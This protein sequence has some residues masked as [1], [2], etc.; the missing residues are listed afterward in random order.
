MVTGSCQL[1]IHVTLVYLILRFLSKALLTELFEERQHLMLK[2]MCFLVLA[3]AFD[4][5]LLLTCFCFAVSLQLLCFFCLS[6]PNQAYVV[7]TYVS[8]PCVRFCTSQL[9]LRQSLQLANFPKALDEKSF[10]VP[11]EAFL[12]HDT[13]RSLTDLQETAQWLG[14]QAVPQSILEALTGYP[15]QT[16]L[17]H[18][19]FPTPAL[20]LDFLLSSVWETV[21]CR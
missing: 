12:S 13:R 8:L 3:V 5:A 11:G 4:F 7:S 6:E 17:C 19:V 14:G 15:A 20:A 16:G 2:P 21:A 1:H 18:V 9:W 10:V